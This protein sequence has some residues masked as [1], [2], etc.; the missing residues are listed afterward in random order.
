M[1]TYY[2]RDTWLPAQNTVAADDPT[3]TVLTMVLQLSKNLEFLDTE[4][5]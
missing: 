4:S 5:L 1:Y 3:V 2:Y